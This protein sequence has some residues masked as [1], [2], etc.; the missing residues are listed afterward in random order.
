LSSE[1]DGIHVIDM[2]AVAEAAGKD[3]EKPPFYYSEERQQHI[4]K[5][6]ACDQSTDILG[7]FGYLPATAG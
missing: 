6:A 5:C 2:Y 4:F 3:A 7:R 1:E